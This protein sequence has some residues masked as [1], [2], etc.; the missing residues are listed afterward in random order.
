MTVLPNPFLS[1]LAPVM[2]ADSAAGLS[3]TDP[4]VPAADYF[5]HPR[6]RSAEA[7]VASNPHAPTDAAVDPFDDEPLPLFLTEPCPIID[8]GLEA[9]F[10]VHFGQAYP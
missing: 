3:F 1:A 5:T 2:A 10:R 9:L 4:S 6:P 8:R 7:T